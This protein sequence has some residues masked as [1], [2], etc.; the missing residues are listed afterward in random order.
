MYSVIM[1]IIGIGIAVIGGRLG[2][3]RMLYLTI[4]FLAGYAAVSLVIGFLEY[5]KDFLS[6]FIS[7]PN[8]MIIGFILLTLPPLLL[9]PYLG[10]KLMVKLAIPDISPKLDAI[11][12]AGYSLAVYVGILQVI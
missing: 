10:R 11:L 12:G 5:L 7:D 6:N 1:T 3:S 8:A 2:L 9:I 4:A